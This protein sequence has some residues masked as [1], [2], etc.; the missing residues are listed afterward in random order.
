MMVEVLSRSISSSVEILRDINT[1]EIIGNTNGKD[2]D[3]VH[4]TLPAL[5]L[6]PDYSNS[7]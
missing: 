4:I 5:R 6:Q 3:G 1:G 2:V 7:L